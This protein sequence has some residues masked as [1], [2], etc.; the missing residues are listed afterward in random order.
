MTEHI[1]SLYDNQ[2]CA[3]SIPNYEIKSVFQKEIIDK[4]NGVFT[5]V[6]L[7]SFEEAIRTGNAELLTET[8]QKYLVQSA[9]AFDVSHE[10][11]K[12]CFL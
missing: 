10:D 1:G 7:R 9:S 8:L 12:S 2:I 6:L 5:G 11:L 4:Y 3:L